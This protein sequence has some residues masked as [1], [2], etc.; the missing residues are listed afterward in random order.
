MTNGNLKA[1]AH[2]GAGY[3]RVAEEILALAAGVG[4]GAGLMYLYDPDR[5]RSRRKRLTAEATGLLHRGEKVI[6]KH[7]TD[8]VNR[9]RGLMFEATS[10]FVPEEEVDDDVLAERVRSRMGHVLARPHEVHVH[11]QKGVITLEGN[12]SR[13]DR[14]RLTEEVEGV[15]GVKRVK[16]HLAPR[17]AA[18]P[19]LLMGLAAGLAVASNVLFSHARSKVG[20]AG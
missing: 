3:R 2:N 19:G 13:A 1:E 5:G 20:H 8:L 4:A 10:A 12:L 7:G 9:A 16:D 11:A 14:A 15:P 6:E 18:T 17:S